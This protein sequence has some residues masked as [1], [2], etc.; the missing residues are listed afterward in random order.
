MRQFS[1]TPLEYNKIEYCELND[2]LGFYNLDR[3]IIFTVIQN[4]SQEA[5]AIASQDS[6]YFLTSQERL[7]LSFS[8]AITKEVSLL[9]AKDNNCTTLGSALY[10]IY[11]DTRFTDK[12]L[13]YLLQVAQNLA[14]IKQGV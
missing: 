10:T 2:I 9:F 4:L 3:S 5:N 12:D 1:K 14:N 7:V 13:L 6:E 11:N 8:A